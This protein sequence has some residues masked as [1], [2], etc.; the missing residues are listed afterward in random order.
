[1]KGFESLDFSLSIC[2]K[3]VAE[4]K[5]LLAKSSSLEEGK[6]LQPFFKA[7]KHL[8]AMT[9][10]YNRQVAR[11]DLVAWEYDLFGDFACDL[12]VGDSECKAYCFIEFE[13]ATAKSLFVRQ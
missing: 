2:R 6:H 10:F 7:R 8:S 9:G 1:M 5:Q 4:L 3:E 11:F 13:D 12:A